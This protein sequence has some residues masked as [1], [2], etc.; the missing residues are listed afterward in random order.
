M[1]EGARNLMQI[2]GCAC[3]DS[4]DMRIRFTTMSIT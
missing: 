2:K 4:L 3:K 1:G